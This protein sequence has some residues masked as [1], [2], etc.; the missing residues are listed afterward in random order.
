VVTKPGPNDRIVVTGANRV[1]IWRLSNDFEFCPA[2]ADGIRIKSDAKG[3]FVENWATDSDDGDE[4]GDRNCKRRYRWRDLNENTAEAKGEFDYELRFRP[5]DGWATQ[6]ILCR[7][8]PW[9]VN[10]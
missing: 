6:G 1:I 10:R 7:L 3:Q 2:N 9:V 5:K 4:P 8:D